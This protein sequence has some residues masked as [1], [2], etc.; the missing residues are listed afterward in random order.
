M[1]DDTR[2]LEVGNMLNDYDEPLSP[3]KIVKHNIMLFI[4]V[5]REVEGPTAQEVIAANVTARLVREK[6]YAVFHELGTKDNCIMNKLQIFHDIAVLS[7]APG[8]ITILGNAFD[9]AE[10]LR[11]LAE[12]RNSKSPDVHRCKNCGEPINFMNG[13]VFGYDYRETPTEY[14]SGCSQCH[15]RLSKE[16][17]S[18]TREERARRIALKNQG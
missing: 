7:F 1:K 3:R 9:A 17:D 10:Q 16:W 18:L 12:Q 14:I 11:Q 8:G 15:T 2:H 6:G 5:I 4:E 13:E